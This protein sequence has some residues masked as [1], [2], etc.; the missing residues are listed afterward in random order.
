MRSS[1]FRNKKKFQKFKIFCLKLNLHFNQLSADR[2]VD[3]SSSFVIESARSDFGFAQ[4]KARRKTHR[5]IFLAHLPSVLCANAKR[6]H[7]PLRDTSWSL[8]VASSTK[9]LRRLGTRQVPDAIVS[10]TV[11]CADVVKRLAKVLEESVRRTDHYETVAF[12]RKRVMGSNRKRMFRIFGFL[13]SLENKKNIHD[14]YRRHIYLK[15]R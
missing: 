7:G 11:S 12:Y 14:I 13:I 9:P 15:T 10:S 4:G 2:R 3:R 6:S 5:L 8:P 1:K